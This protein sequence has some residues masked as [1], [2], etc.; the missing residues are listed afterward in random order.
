[1]RK[2]SI[3]NHSLLSFLGQVSYSV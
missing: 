2:A 3:W 1:L